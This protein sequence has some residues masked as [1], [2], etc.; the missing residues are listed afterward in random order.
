MCYAFL[1]DVMHKKIKFDQTK[2]STPLKSFS[3][4]TELFSYLKR[5]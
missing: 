4:K 2:I 1:L 3:L 5:K